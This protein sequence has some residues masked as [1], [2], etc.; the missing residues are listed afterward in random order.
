MSGIASARNHSGSEMPVVT[1]QAMTAANIMVTTGRTM[2]R[3][4]EFIGFIGFVELAELVEFVE[5]VE[6]IELLSY[7]VIGSYSFVSFSPNNLI[8]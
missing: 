8:S 1:A 5:F 2:A 7:W 3:N 4:K 6:F